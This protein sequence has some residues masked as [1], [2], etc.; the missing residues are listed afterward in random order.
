MNAMYIYY[1]AIITPSGKRYDYSFKF[2]SLSQ[3]DAPR[4]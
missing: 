3:K 1:F 2:E 4:P